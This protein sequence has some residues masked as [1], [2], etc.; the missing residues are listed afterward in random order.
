MPAYMRSN[1]RKAL[2]VNLIVPGKHMPE[3]VFPVQSHKRHSVSV[4]EQ[5]S[6]VSINKLL[7]PWRF[8]VLDYFSEA[9][10]DILCHRNLPRTGVCLGAFNVNCH[11]SALKLMV[12][13]QYLPVKVN[14]LYSKTAELRNT[15]SCVEEYVHSL[16]ILAVTVVIVSTISL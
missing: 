1:F 15:K 11:A 6:A 4:E 3:T 10:V 9:L 13:V 8:S 7:N 12:D 14:I 16:V 5:K 2:P